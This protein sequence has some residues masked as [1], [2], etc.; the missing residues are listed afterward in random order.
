M[1]DTI[2]IIS[3]FGVIP[4]IVW[5]VYFFRSKAHARASNL[6]DKM[7]DR[8]DAITP[9]LVRTLGIRSDTQHGD[10]KTGM[11]LIAIALALIVFGQVVPEEEAGPITA[12]LAMFPLLV[13]IAYTAFWFFF[14]RKTPVS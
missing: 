8:G 11:I 9:E 13:G 4:L 5:L 3:V 12:G 14:G 6:V 1:E 10:L 2:A 7:I